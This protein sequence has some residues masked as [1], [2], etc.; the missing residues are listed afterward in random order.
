LIKKALMLTREA[1][2][3]LFLNPVGDAAPEKIRTERFGRFGPEQFAVADAQI[4]DW[5]PG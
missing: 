1:A 5:Y 2:I 4:H 3:C